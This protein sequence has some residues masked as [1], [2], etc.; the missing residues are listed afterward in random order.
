MSSELLMPLSGDLEPRDAVRQPEVVIEAVDLG[1]AYSMYA[2]PVDRLKQMF[3]PQV[4][5]LFRMPQVAY[6]HEF[7]ALRGLSFQVGRGETVGI[8][9]R[10]GSGKSTLLQ[11]ICGTLQPTEGY[12]RTTGRIA[13]LL[14]L[15]AG[16]NP[17]FTGKEN[18]L[19][20]GQVLGLT[21]AEIDQRYDDIVSFADIGEFLDQPVKTYS[22]GMYVRLAFAVAIHTSPELLIIDEALAVGDAKFNAKCMARIKKLRESGLSILFVSH[23]V[24]AVRSLCDRSIWLD[25]GKP[26]LSGSVFAVT[27]QY[28]QHLFEEDA[29]RVESER[30]QVVAQA[31]QEIADDAAQEQ[32]RARKP[33]NHWGSHIGSIV[34]VDTEDESGQRRNMFF[35][36][37]K[38]HIRLRVRVPELVNRQ[39]LSVAFSLK[40]MAGSDLIVGTTWD[41]PRLSLDS[42]EKVVEVC[43][44][45]DCY[46]R[47]GDYVL[48]AALEDRSSDNIQYFEYIEGAQYLKVFMK[49][50]RYGVFI[51]PIEKRLL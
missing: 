31:E 27:A 12:V 16:F 7:W 6:S 22:S 34:S 35:T 18:L 2:K 20:N 8:I 39:Y 4:R 50:H 13:A 42:G 51:A 14:E 28:M 25:K 15:G 37:E 29:A 36:G 10:N 40:D 41:E 33:V 48:V 21:K 45:L 24:G 49:E 32:L 3:M 43:F 1:K 9:G 23:D 26:R 44:A 47:E 46:L 30:E 5:S 38:M 11:L 19:L 17:E